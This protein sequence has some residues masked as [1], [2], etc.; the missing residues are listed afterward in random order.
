MLLVSIAVIMLSMLATLLFSLDKPVDCP[1]VA[2]EKWA[3][4]PTDNI[5]IR[6]CG[7]D[8]IDVEDLK[9]IVFIDDSRYICSPEDVYSNLNKSFWELGDVITINTN[10]EWSVN[11]G[12]GDSVSLY[13][14]DMDSK[15]VFRKVEVP[16]GGGCFSGWVCPGDVY[17]TSPGSYSDIESIFQ[18]ERA[19]PENNPENCTHYRI[20]KEGTKD[21]PVFTTW[22]EF[23]FFIDMNNKYDFIL[24]E[25]IS[26]V[27]LNVVY[28]THDSSDLNIRLM[29][30]DSYPP[31]GEWYC[32]NATLPF[33]KDGW[34][35]YTADLS[36]RINVT[37]DLEGLRVRIQ[38]SSTAAAASEK[39]L[40]VDYM[41]ISFT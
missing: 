26:N 24:G 3:R 6:H 40:N 23:V 4:A 30:F 11:L 28:Q 18:E 39:E 8:V 22:E 1:H 35:T 17:E 19:S 38:A 13:L 41:A 15:Q 29:V 36:D 31:V 16:V 20:P 34:G 21:D 5:Y 37:E 27:T 32:E 12:S 33:Y 10:D 14:V 2:V 9:I 7:G 25:P